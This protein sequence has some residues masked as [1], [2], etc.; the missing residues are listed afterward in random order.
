[1]SN[2]L[3]KER[4]VELGVE[5]S[6]DSN[7]P[8]CRS[9]SPGQEKRLF[10]TNKTIMQDAERENRPT[11]TDRQYRIGIVT[12]E[13]ESPYYGRMLD[14]AVSC[15]RNQGHIAIVQ[16]NAAT[17]VGE[18]AACQSLMNFD[19]DGVILHAD[20]L[21]ETEL[22]DLMKHYPHSVIMNRRV[23]NFENRCVY[24]DNVKGGALAALH[25]IE[26]GHRHIA[27]V[28]GPKH[29]FEVADRSSGFI[30]QMVAS[31]LNANLVVEI[32]GDF[33]NDGGAMAMSKLTRLEEPVTAV[34]F[35]NDEM[36]IGAI[37]WCRDHGIRVPEDMS[38][39]GFDDL[40]IYQH[41]I[42]QLSSIRQPLAQIGKASAQCLINL[43]NDSDA[44]DVPQT[45]Q[46]F[47]P[48]LVDRASVARLT[49]D[50]LNNNTPITPVSS[51]EISCIY[52]AAKGKTSWEISVIL[53][54]SESTVVFHLRNAG[55]KLKTVNRTHTVAEAIRLGIISL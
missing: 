39:I 7:Q 2:Q 28:T 17:R 6:L 5:H 47:S 14:S 43:L 49:I 16:S 34:F 15:L 24:F 26:N 55:K 50:Q 35:H 42:P 22:N 44:P 3:V 13:F 38:I 45:E 25:L 52:W 30:N 36:A 19:C 54:V 20:L 1:M 8:A 27:M 10:A 40:P 51:R 53:D 31:K 32:E 18:I 29:F 46:Y 48:Q 33:C 41:T 11:H 21:T 4:Q 12:N 9:I 37:G 23:E